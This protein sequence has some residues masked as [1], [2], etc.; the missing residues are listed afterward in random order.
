[1]PTEM[2][3]DNVEEKLTAGYWELFGKRPKR[4]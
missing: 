4:G 1:M 2:V 3:V